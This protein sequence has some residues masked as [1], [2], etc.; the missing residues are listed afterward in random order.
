M[1]PILLGD[2]VSEAVLQNICRL[3]TNLVDSRYGPRLGSTK[4]RMMHA[5]GRLGV[6]VDK[7]S[8]EVEQE[9]PA[10]QACGGKKNQGK[11]NILGI[12]KPFRMPEMSVR[13]SGMANTVRSSPLDVGARRRGRRLQTLD[14]NV[15]V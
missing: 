1:L 3:A 2:S 12:L 4:S 10:R 15:L 14:L 13:E 5:T 7:C 9:W 8:S 11:T 6:N